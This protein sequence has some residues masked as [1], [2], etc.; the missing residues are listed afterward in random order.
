MF[1]P[2]RP[3]GPGEILLFVG[4]CYLLSLIIFVPLSGALVRWRVH[5]NPR[6]IELEDTE[7]QLEREGRCGIQWFMSTFCLEKVF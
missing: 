2:D 6:G 4:C 1:W 7:E 5:Y 3:P